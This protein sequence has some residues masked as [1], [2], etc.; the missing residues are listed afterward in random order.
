[1]VSGKLKLKRDVRD[2]Q[3]RVSL[4]DLDDEILARIRAAKAWDVDSKLGD[5]QL[6]VAENGSVL[7]NLKTRRA[8]LIYDEDSDLHDL[9]DLRVVKDP[10]ANLDKE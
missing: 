5:F 9:Q 10:G 7:I 3:L 6:K 4:M 2:Y 8:Q 1:V